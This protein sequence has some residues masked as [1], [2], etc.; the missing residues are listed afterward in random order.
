VVLHYLRG[1]FEV[2]RT[3]TIYVVVGPDGFL[4]LVVDNHPRALRARTSREHHDSR[5]GVGISS[6][7]GQGLATE[8]LQ[9][10]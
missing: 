7:A 10:S 4:Q 8:E 5:T 6:L 1:T 9:C 3:V 2:F